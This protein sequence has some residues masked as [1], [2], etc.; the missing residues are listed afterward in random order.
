MDKKTVKHKNPEKSI[1]NNH[2][3][4]E[5]AEILI[6]LNH[7][8]PDEFP[9]VNIP[10]RS[11]A[12]ITIDDILKLNITVNGGSLLFKERDIIPDVA[13]DIK[14]L[15]RFLSQFRQNK[16][17]TLWIAGLPWSFNSTAFFNR[18]EKQL[19]HKAVAD[20]L[21]SF[22]YLED[23]VGKIKRRNPTK[24]ESFQKQIIEYCKKHN[25]SH[26]DIDVIQ[27]KL[28][29]DVTISEIKKWHQQKLFKKKI[30]I[31]FKKN[32]IWVS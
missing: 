23:T 3:I 22:G 16:E 27:K 15:F 10:D 13:R 7:Y 26:L 12:Y 5:I 31:D 11:I 29:S 19:G 6:K 25:V 30:K 17:R 24:F 1:D 14:L 21:S 20:I 9:T 18:F 8:L 2:F 28:N 32:W 4:H